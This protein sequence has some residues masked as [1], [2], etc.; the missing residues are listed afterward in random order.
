MVII[1]VAAVLL[2]FLLLFEY[3]KSRKGILPIKTVTS[4]LF[5][6]AAAMQPHPLHSYFVLLL[7][8]LIL[9]LGGDVCLALPQKKAF[10]VGLIL[11]LLG[12]VLYIV[13]FLQAPSFGSLP[14][15]SVVAT[16]GISTGVY[17]WLRPHLGRMHGPVAAYVIVI[18]AMVCMAWVMSGNQSLHIAGRSLAVIGAISF[19]LSD[20][21]VA[22]DRFLKTSFVNRLVG[23]PA[24]YTGQFLLAFSVGLM[25]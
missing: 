2:G 1:G 19:Y 24:Y 15:P 17:L 7:V 23:L 25:K 21:F 5:V 14:W 10:L 8:G 22:R 3:K 9:C 12:H 11:F 13:A 18:T 16:L 4:A 20:L 6:V